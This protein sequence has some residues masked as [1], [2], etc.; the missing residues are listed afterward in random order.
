MRPS[1]TPWTKLAKQ[2]LPSEHGSWA[3][4]LEPMLIGWLAFRGGAEDALLVAGF[5]GFLAYRP[6]KLAFA[7]LSKHKT[8]PRTRPALAMAGGLTAAL[9]V[10]VAFSFPCWTAEWPYLAATAWVGA[11]FLL[12]DRQAKPRSLS[13]ELAGACL[14][15]PLLAGALAGKSWPWALGL[16]AYLVIRV[17]ATVLSVRAVFR[18]TPDWRVCQAVAIVAGLALIPAELALRRWGSGLV[19]PTFAPIALRSVWLA[20][21]ANVHREANKVGV[22][23][24]AFSASVVALWAARLWV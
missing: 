9:L 17:L 12:F 4:V 22:V 21:T 7:D 15:T 5:F 2:L 18:R 13:R 19:L 14:M 23:E 11:A 3:F 6:G 10:C 16:L 24:S 8:Y 1:T 20:A